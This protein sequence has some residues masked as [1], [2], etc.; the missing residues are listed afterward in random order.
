MHQ[1]R[2]R[3]KRAGEMVEIGNAMLGHDICAPASLPSAR[4]AQS[5]WNSHSFKAV[6][7]MR[8]YA[9]EK[10]Y[11]RK[12]RQQP[13]VFILCDEGAR[14]LVFPSALQMNFD[15]VKKVHDSRHKVCIG[16][17]K[18]NSHLND[19][20]SGE[21]FVNLPLPLLP[22]TQMTGV[23]GDEEEEA[24]VEFQ[25]WIYHQHWLIREGRTST[26]LTRA[27][28]ASEYHSKKPFLIYLLVNDEF[29]K[30]NACTLDAVVNRLWIADLDFFKGY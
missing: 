17:I 16:V 4:G 11:E 29:A 18:I 19:L 3:H 6:T 5:M 23:C 24:E 12:K 13:Y 20:L 2:D 14:E 27:G 7:S 22:N 10:V 25:A 8:S 21:V 30:R 9:T 15:A 1:S 26:P 28:E